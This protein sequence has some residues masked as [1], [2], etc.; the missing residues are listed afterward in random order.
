MLEFHLVSLVQ[1]KAR[2]LCAD[3]ESPHKI[4]GIKFK[5]FK[6]MLQIPPIS[7]LIIVIKSR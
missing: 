3:V 7:Q 2:D 1:S 5:N 4:T 6:T